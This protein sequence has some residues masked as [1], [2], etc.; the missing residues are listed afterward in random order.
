MH[1][2]FIRFIHISYRVNICLAIKVKDYMGYLRLI[3]AVLL[4]INSYLYK[5]MKDLELILV[6]KNKGELILCYIY[7]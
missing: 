5:I 2:V 7:W 4:L 6:E 1:S 3:I